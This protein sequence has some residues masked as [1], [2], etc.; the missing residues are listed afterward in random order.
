MA[1]VAFDRAIKS[2]ELHKL[3]GP[4]AHWR[5]VRK[6]IHDD[7]CEHGFDAEL[8]HFVQSYGGKE[9]DASLLLLPALGFLPPEDKR[10]RATI[11]AIE[12]ELTVDGLVL[13][14]DSGKT[15]DGLPEGEGLFLACSFWLADAL[16]MIGRGDEARRLFERLL[17]LRNDLGLLSEEYEPRTR[18]LVGNFPQAFSHLALVN[19]ASNLSHYD[20]PAEQ[21]SEHPVSDKDGHAR[22]GVLARAFAP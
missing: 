16:L 12:R 15:D 9:L 18:Q 2:A 13:R 3:E 4:V 10:V 8:G 6:R 21:R 17:T 7:V 1:W 5:S 14:Y 20:K 22:D 11:E 19:T